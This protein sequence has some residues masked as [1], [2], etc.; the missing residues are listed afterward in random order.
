M[1]KSGRGNGMCK[2]P[3]VGRVSCGGRTEKILTDR[4]R[5]WGPQWGY[6]EEMRP[7]K[8]SR[9][10]CKLYCH[11]VEEFIFIQRNGTF[12]QTGDIGIFRHQGQP[13]E[14]IAE[15]LYLCFL[16]RMEKHDA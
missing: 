4:L 15:D 8:Y 1:G 9:L 14:N 12:K 5:L 11:H 2:W 7:V 10:C 3:G 13:N 6:L 16:E